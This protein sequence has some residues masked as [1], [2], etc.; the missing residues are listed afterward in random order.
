MS[1]DG[2]ACAQNRVH[3]PE[4][5]FLMRR[6]SKIVTPVATVVF[7]A[8]S[9]VDMAFAADGEVDSS[10]GMLGF[11]AAFAVAVA[12]FGGALGQGRAAAAGLEGIA[13]NPQAQNKIFIPMIVALA[14]IES[15]VIYGLII[16]FIIKP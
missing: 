3:T 13:R 9:R 8:L 5:D 15:L 11:A 16:A 4:E 10:R 6:L 12:A 7:M 14:F 2:N 1:T